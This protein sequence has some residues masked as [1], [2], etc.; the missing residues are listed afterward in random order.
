MS[1]M[2][3][4]FYNCRFA[5]YFN[6]VEE[7]VNAAVAAATHPR[8]KLRWLTCLDDEAQR[9]VMTSVKTAIA[10]GYQRSEPNKALMEV[11]D[12]DDFNFGPRNKSVSVAQANLD[13]GAGETQFTKFCQDPKKTMVI[14]HVYPAVKAVYMK[15]NTLLPSSASVERMFSF[16]T[17]FDIAKFNRLT[18]SNFEKRVLCRANAVWASPK[19]QKPKK[20]K[21]KK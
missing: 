3:L 14:L 8:F 17:M 12:D 11:D 9:I 16:A 19:D 1:H 5:N 13:I 10:A 21:G 4:F 15:Y 18:D 2:S 7:G 20:S 6:V